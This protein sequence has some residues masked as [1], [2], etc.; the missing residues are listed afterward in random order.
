MAHEGVSRWPVESIP[1]EDLL[2]KRV[3][4]RLLKDDGSIM[5]GAFKDTE[6]STDWSRY[7]TPDDSRARARHPAVNGVAALRAGDVR[8]IEGQSV[9]HAPLP[10]NRAHA[11]VVG[12]K[13]PEVRVKLRRACSLV[14]RADSP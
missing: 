3:H 11:N 10:E 4:L 6:M 8:L 13:S 12:Q 9:E 2:Y 14:I 7:S 1:D 5:T